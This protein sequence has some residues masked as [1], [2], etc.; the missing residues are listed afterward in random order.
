MLAAYPIMTRHYGITLSQ[1]DFLEEA[2]LV[3]K[4][5]NSIPV[6]YYYFVDKPSNQ[7]DMLIKLPCN[8]Y[9][10][11]SVSSAPINGDNYHEM[12]P[13]RDSHAELRDTEIMTRNIIAGNSDMK[14]YNLNDTP[15]VGLGSYIAFEWVDDDTIKIEDKRL[16]DTDIHIVYEGIAVDED[17]I[18]MITRKHANAIAAKV[19]Y[20]VAT[21]RMFAGD[22][23]MAQLI[24]TLSQEA[25]RLMQAAAIPEH[26]TDNELDEVLNEF[27]RFDRKRINRSFKFRR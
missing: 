7:E 14:T 27:A 2:Y 18:P 3:F 15:Y 5:I 10:V 23:L 6:K 8:V 9:R 22:Q 12:E 25:A 11:L 19:A 20:I 21:R 1:D 26:V 16:V 13:Y 24:P 4:D 17:G